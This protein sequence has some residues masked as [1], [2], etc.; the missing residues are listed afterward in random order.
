MHFY[1]M[2][3]AINGGK[4]LLNAIAAI[5]LSFSVSAAS[6]TPADYAALAEEAKM[7]TQEGLNRLVENPSVQ[8]V[9]AD[10]GHS[11]IHDP[12]GQLPKI[13]EMI[14]KSGSATVL[15]I[16][17]LDNLEW[18]L[19]IRGEAE[20]K[21]STALENEFRTKAPEFLA[22]LPAQAILNLAEAKSRA[23]SGLVRR[24]PT[25]ASPEI[26]LV[27]NQEGFLHLQSRRDIRSLR[28]P[29]LEGAA[30][31]ELDPRALDTASKDGYA[32]VIISLKM[33]AGYSAAQGYMSKRAWDSQVSS[34]RSAMN[35]IIG[36]VYPQAVP[37]IQ[38]Y[39][40]LAGGSVVLPLG[41]LRSLY[42]KPD[43]RIQ[44]IRLNDPIE[45]ALSISTGG[46]PGGVN[47]QQLWNNFNMRG[48]GQFVAVLDTGTES[49]HAFFDGKSKGPGCYGTILTNWMSVCPAQ[50]YTG[51]SVPGS[52][53]AAAPC[54]DYVFP[55]PTY[56]PTSMC[57]HGT[58]VAGVAV[59]RNGLFGLNG[60]APDAN[61]FM[62][63]IFSRHRLTIDPATG[64][65][66]RAAFANDIVRGLNLIVQLTPS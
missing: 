41:A 36:S 47:V 13:Q 1:W 33:P 5:T 19:G 4:K 25:V 17:Q 38:H 27:V 37:L 60:V 16:Q 44:S 64:D 39:D 14:D 32:S 23:A 35:D 30:P 34:L 59:G 10:P 58:A 54:G 42:D 24:S 18:G 63:N 20:F 56:S 49:E 8:R 28:M 40:G 66:Q 65:Y 61:L 46:G 62:V 31:V 15:I 3:Q 26:V 45:P 9:M 7:V 48:A 52:I 55:T 21:F 43:P 29:E 51:A 50:D 2:S 12:Y 6:I 22:S 57:R 11:V 53:G